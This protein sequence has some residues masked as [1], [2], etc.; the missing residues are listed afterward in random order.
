M[1]KG[2][3][4]FEQEAVRKWFYLQGLL[5]GGNEFSERAGFRTA[6]DAVFDATA[7]APDLEEAARFQRPE[8]LA[9]DRQGEAA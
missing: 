8:R 7:D 3:S 2:G 6:W 5:Q 1:S 9:D 4:E